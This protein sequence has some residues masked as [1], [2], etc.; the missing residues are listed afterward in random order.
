MISFGGDV[1]IWGDGENDA[2]TP[3]LPLRIVYGERAN[4]KRCWLVCGITRAERK[5]KQA[6][7]RVED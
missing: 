3:R 6:P 2:L 7:V 4:E 5:E 1:G